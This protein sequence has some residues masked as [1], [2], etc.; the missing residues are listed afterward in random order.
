MERLSWV[1]TT[2]WKPKKKKIEF[3]QKCLK[4]N[5][6]LYFDFCRRADITLALSLSVLHWLLLASGGGEMTPGPRV[7]WGWC[8][9][10][11]RWWPGRRR[12]TARMKVMNERSRNRSAVGAGRRTVR[13]LPGIVRPGGVPSTYPLGPGPWD[14]WD[15]WRGGRRA[16]IWSVEWQSGLVGSLAQPTEWR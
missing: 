3:F 1:L 12:P 5:F 10:D 2:Q 13:A 9:P 4:L 6:D 16:T 8:G 14:E 15:S 11:S 7:R